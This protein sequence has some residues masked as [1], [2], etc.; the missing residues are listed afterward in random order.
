MVRIKRDADGNRLRKPNP[1]REY[2]IAISQFLLDKDIAYE[3]GVLDQIKTQRGAMMK[4]VTARAEAQKA[5]QDRLTAEAKGKAAV[6]K[7]RYAAEV[8]KERAVVNAQREK[9]VAELQAAKKLAVAKLDRETAEQFKQA[10]ILR[11]QGE[12]ERKRL[13]LPADGALRPSSRHTRP[14]RR[15]G[16]R[17]SLL[18]R[19]PIPSSGP[20][21]EDPARTA[22]FRPRSSC[23]R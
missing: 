12:A 2:S 15:A 10:E 4:T 13:A 11:G 9:Q 20:A 23:G 22:T 19:C 18:E 16:R 7:A 14:S 17:P 6:M 5:E 1:L 3:Q 21:R 8:E